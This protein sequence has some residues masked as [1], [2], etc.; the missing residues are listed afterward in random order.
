MAQ[1]EQELLL[2]GKACGFPSAS[3]RSKGV[4]MDTRDQT[5]PSD[6]METL[7]PGFT[8]ED[9]IADESPT[10]ELDAGLDDELLDEAEIGRTESAAPGEVGEDDSDEYSRREIPLTDLPD[11]PREEFVHSRELGDEN[12]PGDVDIEDL[13]EDAILDALPPDARLDPLEE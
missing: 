9:D 11:A 13:D 6:L 10:T 1:N 2:D 4:F 5:L 8:P 3:Y 7:T 12:T